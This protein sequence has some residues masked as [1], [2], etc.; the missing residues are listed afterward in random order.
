MRTIEIKTKGR[1]LEEIGWLLNDLAIDFV[2][3]NDD[4]NYN[5]TRENE[6]A[7]I[8]FTIGGEDE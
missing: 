8:E 1:N 6:E 2:K 3:H 5:G 7:K 4:V